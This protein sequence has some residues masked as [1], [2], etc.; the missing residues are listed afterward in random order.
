M[1]TL[2]IEELSKNFGSTEVWR[3][4]NLEIDEG[5]FLVLLG[6]SGCGKST[7]LN[8]IAGLETINEGN[9][10][11]DDYNV[12]K[13]EPKDRN[14][15]MVFQSYALYPSMNVR[16]KMIFGLKQAKT[17]KEKIEEQ[18]EKVS[19]FLQVD[20]L[21][22]RKPSQLS[23]GQRQ[24]VA[25]GRAITRNPKIFLFDEPLSNLDAALRAEMRVE[26]SKLHNQIKTNMIYVTHDQV[27]AMT[28]A[29]RIVILNQGNIEQVGT[30]EEIYNDPANIFVA[31]FIGTPKMNILDVKE[32]NIVSENTIKLLGNDIQFDKLKLNKSKHFV[33]IRPEH[34][35]IKQNTQFTFNPE[36]ELIENLGNEKIV[37]MKKDEH[38]L[39]A[40]I[41]S[42]IEVGNSIGFDL[43]DIFIFDE[44]GNRLK[45]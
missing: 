10:F 13:V 12:S 8:I 4:I 41:P 36:I 22:E 30:P 38:Q 19:K 20:Q 24:R 5:N 39:S 40:K 35:K 29:D 37:Y 32:E 33:G 14:I 31:Q 2:K 6:P 44:N 43:N 9:V 16:E 7:L 1:K 28:L 25:I 17:S 23:G 42:N 15:A 34:L 3:K 26:I 11:I 18:L 45:S 27:E 21:L